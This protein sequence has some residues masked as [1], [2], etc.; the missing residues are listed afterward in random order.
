MCPSFTTLHVENRSGFYNIVLLSVLYRYL[1]RISC[2]NECG[3]HY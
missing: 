1:I 2:K 3:I